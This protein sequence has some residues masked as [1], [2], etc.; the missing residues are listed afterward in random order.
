MYYAFYSLLYTGLSATQSSTQP[1]GLMVSLSLVALGLVITL[2][3]LI[4]LTVVIIFLTKTKVK[5]QRKLQ[6]A[7]LYDEIGIPPSII[8]SSMNVAY[9]TAIGHGT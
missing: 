2:I 5:I 3:V 9:S 7:T 8:D 1:V 6:Q 4:V